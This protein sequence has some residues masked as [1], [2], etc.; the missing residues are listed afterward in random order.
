MAPYRG[1]E[2][3][4]HGPTCPAYGTIRRMA[5]RRTGKRKAQRSRKASQGEGAPS[6]VFLPDYPEQVKAIA[7]RGLSDDEMAAVFGISADLMQAWKEYYP[8]FKKAIAEGRTA[9]DARV[10]QALFERATGYSHPEVRL[11][12]DEGE[13]IE[14][15]VT[16]HYPPDH[17]SIKTW[18]T[19]RQREH[20]KDRQSH[21]HGGSRDMPDIGVGVGVRDESK[22]EL[23]A[24][25]L[26]L[27]QPQPDGD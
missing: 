9:A 18:L 19:N 25:I 26:G 5:T 4:V 27:I 8:E 12:F 2:G 14:H 16:K 17:A 23:I 20:W 22:Q 10:V 24:S 7:M 1:A 3:N 6:T 15:E 11:F 21:E 13:V